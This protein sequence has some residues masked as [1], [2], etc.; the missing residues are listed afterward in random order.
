MYAHWRSV[1]AHHRPL[2]VEGRGRT[3]RHQLVEQADRIC[4]ILRPQVPRWD[5][6]A[7]DAGLL[8]VVV[9]KRSGPAQ[10]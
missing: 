2:L 1:G 10:A 7:I 6:Y 3:P 4:S 9:L 8:T 5:W